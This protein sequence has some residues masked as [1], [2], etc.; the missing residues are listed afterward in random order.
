MNNKIASDNVAHANRICNKKLENGNIVLNNKC[1]YPDNFIC[2]SENFELLCLFLLFLLFYSL[3]NI[4]SLTKFE[5]WDN[6]FILTLITIKFFIYLVT[7]LY[8]LFKCN[9]C[10]SLKTTISHEFGH[11]IG[12]EHPDQHYYYNYKSSY[13]KCKITKEI[14]QQYD[15]KSIMISTYNRRII[16]LSLDD[17]LGLYD[18]YPSCNFNTSIY[19]NFEPFN[20]NNEF[21]FIIYTI[22]VVLTVI[23]IFMYKLCINFKIFI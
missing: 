12:F 22:F 3:L 5:L 9:N 7:F 16:Q 10:Y 20:I 4:I 8:L 13:N 18:L 11:I 17:K 1:F 2:I 23:F 15:K 6:N 14:D 21:F 19:N